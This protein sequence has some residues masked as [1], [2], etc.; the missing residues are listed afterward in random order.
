[1]CWQ[2]WFLLEALGENL[3]LSLFQL[4]VATQM[5]GLMA[6]SQKLHGSDLCFCHH[7]L[8]LALLPPS[9]T[10]KDPSVITL[11]PLG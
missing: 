11:G 8:S 9:F 5:P 4:L 6:P 1:M 7:I 2:G 10:Y 3:L